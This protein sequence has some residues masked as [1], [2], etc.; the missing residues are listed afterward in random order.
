[1]TNKPS[2]PGD[3]LAG[4]NT[5]LETLQIRYRQ[6]ASALEEFRHQDRRVGDGL[7][8]AGGVPRHLERQRS[9][10][11]EN[12]EL[13][14]NELVETGIQISELRLQLAKATAY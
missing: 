7:E 6:L 1:M 8:R 12:I 10:L 5:Q 13:T 14:K 4:L 11:T 3:T 9:V 2:E